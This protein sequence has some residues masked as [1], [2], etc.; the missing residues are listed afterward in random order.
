MFV[1]HVSKSVTAG[2][3]RAEVAAGFG[4]VSPSIGGVLSRMF[5][6]VLFLDLLCEAPLAACCEAVFE[7]YTLAYLG[8]VTNIGSGFKLEE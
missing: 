5:R 2:P 3:Q 7:D 6:L 1:H 8:R 4:I